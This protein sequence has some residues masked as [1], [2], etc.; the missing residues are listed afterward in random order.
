[1]EDNLDKLIKNI[2][3][4]NAYSPEQGLPDSIFYFVGRNTPFINVDLLIRDSNG[5]ILMTWRDDEYSGKGWHIPGGIIRFQEKINNRINQ[6]ALNELGVEVSKH[7][8]FLEINEII[9]PNKKERSHFIS[10][11][12]ECSIDKKAS[13]TL[14]KIIKVNDKIKFFKKKPKNIL[15]FHKIY[16]KHFK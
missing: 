8:K 1:M 11:L 12:F 9:V 7:N 3:L 14:K 6:V 2:D 16:E 13:A 4:Q 15:H 10:L 5:S